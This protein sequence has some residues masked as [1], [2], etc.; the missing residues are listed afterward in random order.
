PLPDLP[1]KLSPDRELY[2]KIPFTFSYN[3]IFAVERLPFSLLNDN[4]YH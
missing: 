4:N 2:F 1:A 3:Q